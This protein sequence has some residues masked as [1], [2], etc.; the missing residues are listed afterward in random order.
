MGS[1]RIIIH[2]AMIQVLH[3]RQRVVGD[4]GAVQVPHQGRPQGPGR[5][6]RQGQERKQASQIRF[7]RIDVFSHFH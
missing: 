3:G 7:A 6:E 2:N 1:I 4:G 5:E